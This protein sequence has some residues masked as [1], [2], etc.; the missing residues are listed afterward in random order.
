ME[1]QQNGYHGKALPA[2]RET[3]QVG[4]VSPEFFNIVVENVIC[5]WLAMMV[6]YKRVDHNRIE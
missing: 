5:T 3:T 6:E 2:T 4:L 1:L